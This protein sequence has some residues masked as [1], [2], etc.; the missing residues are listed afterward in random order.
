MT[1]NSCDSIERRR[2]VRTIGRTRRS[3]SGT[4]MFRGETPI[5]FESTLERDF[6]IRK[7]F[8]RDVL[9]VISQPVEI[10]FETS[11]GRRFTYTPD[12]LVYYRLGSRDYL[13]YP[14]PLL[15]EVKPKEQWRAN[16]RKWLTKWKAAYR[17]AREQGWSFTIQDESRIRDQAL[18]NIR[19]LDRFKRS[20]FS[21]RESRA[22][23]ETLATMGSAPFH[24]LLSRHFMGIYEAEGIAHIWH[25]LATR[26]LECDISSPLNQQTTIWVPTDE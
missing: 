13:D 26:R 20:A 23:V 10:P 9:E 8:S 17:Y 4:Y 6:L 22:I 14:K 24:Y 15:V 3:V 21:E 25:L 18:R 7:A 1:R 12:F 19:F 5:R 11:D 16:W 2:S